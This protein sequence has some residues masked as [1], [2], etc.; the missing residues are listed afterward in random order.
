MKRH[1]ERMKIIRVILSYLQIKFQKLTLRKHISKERNQR[2]ELSIKELR[3][4][5]FK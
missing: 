1:F 2:K 4:M 3:D 5:K